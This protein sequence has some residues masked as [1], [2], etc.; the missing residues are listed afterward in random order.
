MPAYDLDTGL[1]IPPASFNDAELVGGGAPAAAPAA[2]P[3]IEGNPG[4]PEDGFQPEN[5]AENKP[6]A[7]TDAAQKQKLE[8]AHFAYKRAVEEK[9]TAKAILEEKQIAMNE[10]A[11]ARQKARKAVVN[12]KKAAKSA[13]S[14]EG[15]AFAFKRALIEQKQA[16]AAYKTAVAEYNQAAKG[17][18]AVLGSCKV[19]CKNYSKI[20]KSIAP[21]ARQKQIATV[22]KDVVKGL[23]QESKAAKTVSK[24]PGWLK[25]AGGAILGITAVAAAINL[26]PSNKEEA[27]PEANLDAVEEETQAGE[28]KPDESTAAPANGDNTADDAGKTENN[29]ENGSAAAAE[30]EPE[31]EGAAGTNTGTET[32]VAPVDDAEAE[33][34]DESK[35]DEEITAEENQPIYEV[36][37]G[38]NLW[39]IC[40]KELKDNNGEEP[41]GAQIMARIGEVM[42][43][44]GLHW[45]ADHYHVMIYPKQKLKM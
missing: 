35:V 37:K 10:A 25:I 40:K 38:D 7:K 12:A 1:I 20:L 26:I 43:K 8:K 6:A 45:E 5:P 24:L 3:I 44:N 27:A 9:E 29:T 22:T 34:V 42:E 14:V 36:Q 33:I 41:T 16:N 19:A 31:T 4:A 11:E 17:Y 21:K 39:N 32:S 28:A 15:A 23:K 18:N 30:S 2:E 13:T